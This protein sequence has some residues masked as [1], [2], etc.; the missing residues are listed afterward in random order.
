MQFSNFPG[1][2][3]LMGP[4]IVVELVEISQSGKFWARESGKG[5]EVEPSNYED[6]DA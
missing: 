5:G 1:I 2:S 4:K 3:S 6:Y